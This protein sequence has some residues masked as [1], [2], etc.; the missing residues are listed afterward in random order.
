MKRRFKLSTFDWEAIV[1]I[2]EAHSETAPSIKMM[3]EFWMGWE[4][5]VEHHDGNYT[6]AFLEQL[7]K[8]LIRLS[9]EMDKREIINE[10]A[11]SEGWLRLDGSHGITVCEVEQF[12]ID[13]DIKFREVRP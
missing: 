9:M 4:E 5:R 8:K 13:D 6:A 12:V 1:E 10:L 3:V 11:E 7:G 2:D